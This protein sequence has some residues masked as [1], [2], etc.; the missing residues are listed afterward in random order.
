MPAESEK[1]YLDFF[2]TDHQGIC[3]RKRERPNYILLIKNT[4]G[5][6]KLEYKKKL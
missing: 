5:K 1:I 3:D 6:I 4:T 2:L